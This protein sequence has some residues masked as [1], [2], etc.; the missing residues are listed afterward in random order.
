MGK[1]IGEDP[2]GDLIHGR[3]EDAFKAE[4]VALEGIESE[5]KKKVEVED[6]VGEKKLEKEMKKEKVKQNSFSGP[7]VGIEAQKAREQ[8]KGE[9]KKEET[10]L[11]EEAREVLENLTKKIEVPKGMEEDSLT[12]A[13]RATLAC[14]VVST[15]FRALKTLVILFCLCC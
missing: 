10:Q 7:A 4:K 9:N 1:S 3:G 6:E 8:Q 5:E 2:D 14:L 12:I 15:K 13:E 11:K